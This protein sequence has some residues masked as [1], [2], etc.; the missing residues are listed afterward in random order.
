MAL[1]VDLL[2][3]VGAGSESGPV[4]IGGVRLR[5]LLA[6]LALEGGRPVS[7]DGLV[8]GLWGEQPPADASNALQA[9]VS[10][11]RK[12]LRGHAAVESVGG[13]Y[14][15]DV[16]EADV[17]VHRFEQLAGAGRRAL[18][19]GRGAEAALKLGAALALWRGP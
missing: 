17:D 15:L 1:K 3:P 19:A 2:G 16:T 14:R 13:G 10:R 9:L 5:M 6:R 18:A 7:A 11:L 8:D 12:S 4:E